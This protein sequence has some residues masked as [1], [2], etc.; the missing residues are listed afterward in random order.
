MFGG[1]V[2]M[3]QSVPDRRR[4]QTCG[5]FFFF[6]V[7]VVG[8]EKLLNLWSMEHFKFHIIKS[9]LVYALI[10]EYTV[11]WFKITSV[12]Q[13]HI[14]KWK[15]VYLKM[16]KSL[17]FTR[18]WPTRTA[19]LIQIRQI[20]CLKPVQEGDTSNYTNLP[21]WTDFKNCLVKGANWGHVQFA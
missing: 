11:L 1:A 7:S 20:S 12:L 4:S 16:F 18:N 2:L 9:T 3:I 15:C 14:V 13:N 5:I 8:V 6:P 17:V 21:N 19:H 10:L